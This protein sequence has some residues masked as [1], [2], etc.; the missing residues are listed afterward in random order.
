M[1]PKGAN[2]AA[3]TVAAA[4]FGFSFYVLVRWVE[5]GALSDVGLYQHYANLVRHGA[6]PYRDFRL[7]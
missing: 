1:R 7:E 3:V 6:V 5:R 2:W 4:L